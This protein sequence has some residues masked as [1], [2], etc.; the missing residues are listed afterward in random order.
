MLSGSK[1]V[2]LGRTIL[3]LREFEYREGFSAPTAISRKDS[4]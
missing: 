3:I 4:E 2:T 1:C